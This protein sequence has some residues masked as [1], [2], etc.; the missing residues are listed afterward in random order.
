MSR[1]IPLVPANPTEYL[2]V[3]SRI[4]RGAQAVTPVR[5]ACQ[6]SRVLRI[7]ANTSANIAGVR[8]PVFV[9]RREQW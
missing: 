4:P 7:P 2:A 1:E 9:L 5:H 8:R 6:S 3:L